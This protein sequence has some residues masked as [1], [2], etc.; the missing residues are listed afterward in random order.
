MNSLSILKELPYPAALPNGFWL[1]ISYD[2]LK[3]KISLLTDD[4]DEE[5]IRK[6][7]LWCY[8]NQNLQFWQINLD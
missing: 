4:I 7:V 1:F 3:N 5:F 6:F 2:V 8:E